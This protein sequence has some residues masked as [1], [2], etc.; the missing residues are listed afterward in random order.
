MVNLD[1]KENIFMS[2]YFARHGQ[3]DWNILHK[4]QGTTDIPLNEEGIN[5]ASDKS[6]R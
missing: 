3:T 6:K 2:I 1:L 5:Q 4:V